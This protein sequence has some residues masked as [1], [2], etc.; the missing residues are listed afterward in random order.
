MV[1]KES[2][3]EDYCIIDAPSEAR[4]SKL[5]RLTLSGGDELDRALASLAEQ[6]NAVEYA[7][8][9][10]LKL[11]TAREAAAFYGKPEWQKAPA[12]FFVAPKKLPKVKE[13]PFH[14]LKDGIILDLAFESEYQAVNPQ[15][16]K[17]LA[18]YKE[19]SHV[20]ARVW[21]HN[22]GAKGTLVAVHGW[23]MGDQRINS[24][25]FLPGLFYQ[26]GLDVVLFELPYHGRRQPKEFK[27]QSESLFPS[28]DLVRT[29]E[30]IGQA[31]FDLRQLSMYLQSRG[32][33]NIGCLGMSLGAYI[34][35]LW[36]SLEKLSFCVPTV[37][38]SSMSELAWQ[39][40]SHKP[41]FKELC[42]AGLDGALLQQ[43]FFVHSP[44]SHA[45][46][47][48][49]SKLLIVAGIGD[50][51]LP[52]RQPRLLWEHWKKPRMLWFGGGHAAQIK[53]RETLGEITRF[54]NQVLT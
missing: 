6:F 14:G 3:L 18:G 4:L 34:A 42:K 12:T 20:H 38:L 1:K 54:L 35:A 50:Q 28:A 19:N 23:S 7:D 51:V 13:T 49:P 5:E 21:K 45:V 16:K 48:E 29:N 46:L 33:S 24:L 43:V 25:A 32:Y 27:K 10:P 36:A 41:E 53:R 11:E 2:G 37:P 47:L 26:L 52:P 30:A 17:L 44:L 22:Q 9:G 40:I 8:L 31:I 15:F 39:I